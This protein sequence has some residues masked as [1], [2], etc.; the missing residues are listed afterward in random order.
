MPDSWSDSK[1]LQAAKRIGLNQP[2]GRRVVGVMTSLDRTC[3]PMTRA[4]MAVSV[5]IK[6]E[7]FRTGKLLAPINS[8]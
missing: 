7:N 2:P 5:T 3:S 1:I 8:F 6:H 4:S